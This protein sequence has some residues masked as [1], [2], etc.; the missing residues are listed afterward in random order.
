MRLRQICFVS[1]DLENALSSFSFITGSD[2]CFRDEG[3][4]YFGLKNGLLEVDGNFLEVVSPFK[5]NTTAERFLTRMNG[6]AGYMLIFEC[7]DADTYRKKAVD[8]KIRDIWSSDLKNGVKATHYHPKDIG[9]LIISVDSMNNTNWKNKDSYWQWGGDSWRSN[10]NNKCS[11]KSI[12]MNCINPGSL[13]KRWSSFLNLSLTNNDDRQCIKGDDFEIF[14]IEDQKKGIDYLSQLNLR[15]DNS[16][17]KKE[18]L[19]KYKDNEIVICGTKIEI[20]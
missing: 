8:L 16:A 12:T 5:P 6:D 17:L 1:N 18:I 20:E 7:E 11:I 14:F 9:G 19:N 10:K 2:V 13:A 4:S 15:V 3:V